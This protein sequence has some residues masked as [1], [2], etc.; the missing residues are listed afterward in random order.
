MT[1]KPAGLTLPP[2]PG[3]LLDEN[4]GSTLSENQHHSAC[5]TAITFFD[6]IMVQ[7]GYGKGIADLAAAED[8]TAERVEATARAAAASLATAFVQ[9]HF[10]G[11]GVS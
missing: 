1:R 6:Q 7:C 9:S 8:L 10:P 2:R 11:Q 4:A 3:S 5:T